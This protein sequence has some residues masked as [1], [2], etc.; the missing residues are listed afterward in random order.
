M[1]NATTLTPNSTG[2]RQSNRFFC[3]QLTVMCTTRGKRRLGEAG[4]IVVEAWQM[5]SG[6]GGGRIFR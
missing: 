2:L 4:A 1:K 6:Q 5:C 3:N